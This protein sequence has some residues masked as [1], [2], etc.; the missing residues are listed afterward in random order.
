[1]LTKNFNRVRSCKILHDK[2]FLVGILHN[3]HYADKKFY[4]VRSDKTS[5]KIKN[6]LIRI[7]IL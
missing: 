2:K 4:R 1:M 5:Y 7:F 6:P 3:K